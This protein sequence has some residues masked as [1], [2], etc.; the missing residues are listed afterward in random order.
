L[1]GRLAL[2]AATL[3][4]CGSALADTRSACISACDAVAQTCLRTAHETYEACKPAARTTCATRPPAELPAC[5]G[6]AARTC[7][8][9]HSD[10]TEPCR[11]TFTTCYAQCGPRPATQVD[12]WCTLNADAPTGSGKTYK[13]AFCAGAPGQAPLD[14]HARCMKLF[15]PSNPAIGFSLDC[16]PLR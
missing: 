3:L 14:Q 4:A 8:R 15:T 11:E 13:D 12:F 16:D 6:T 1:N 5:L 7:S 2:L 10:Q 9:T